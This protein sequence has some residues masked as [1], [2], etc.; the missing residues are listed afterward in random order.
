[1]TA[2]APVPLLVNRRSR[3]GEAL[4]HEAAHAL[5]HAGVTA[6]LTFT[7]D[8]GSAER[9]LR[10]AVLAGAP[11]VVVGGGDGSL[12]LAAHALAGSGVTLG[13]LPLG[14]GNT[15]ARSVGVPLDLPGACRVIAE[16][17]VRRVDVGR[18]NGRAF[19]NSAALGTSAE[20]AR[21]L[22]PELKRRLGLL[23]WPWVG[24]K[25]LLRHRAL[26]V[27]VTHG[28]G[29]LTVRTHQVLVANG[30]YVAGP[31]RAAPDASITDGLLDVLILGDA[32]VPSFLRAATGWAAGRRSVRLSAPEL[33]VHAGGSRV[34]V[35]VDG[36]VSSVR[37]LRL[38][39]ERAAL[40]VNVPAGYVPETV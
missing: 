14:T 2:A 22:T 9:A 17:H 12:S 37:D 19:L 16:G 26:Q 28:G 35:S 33:R 36:D 15:F 34:W 27:T 24:L 10:E 18:L 1:M 8:P 3:R 40:N 13:V 21:T 23:A 38:T 39:L 25:V 5:L 30:R 20:I 4:G 7:D 31:L 11:R 32:R 6:R 29:Q